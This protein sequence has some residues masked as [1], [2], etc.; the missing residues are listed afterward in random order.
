[1]PRI[2]ELKRMADGTLWARLDIDLVEGGS[3]SLYTE[4]EIKD[5]EDRVRR[6]IIHAIENHDRIIYER[7]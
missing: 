4:L 5:I 6:E 1:M 3:A 2:C 7:T